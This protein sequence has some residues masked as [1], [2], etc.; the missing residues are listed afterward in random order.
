MGASPLSKLATTEPPGSR[1][2]QSSKRLALIGAG[3]PAGNE[4]F[5]IGP[6]FTTRRVGVQ[7]VT[8]RV[9]ST[10]VEVPELGGNTTNTTVMVREIPAI[11][12]ST[13]PKYTPAVRPVMLTLT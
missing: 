13:W 4:K 10:C 11:T 8:S 3:Q 1:V 2:A 12:R 6:G 5:P 9:F 7:P